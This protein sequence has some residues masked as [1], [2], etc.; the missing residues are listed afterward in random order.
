MC[1]GNLI[2]YFNVYQ[3][4]FNLQYCKTRAKTFYL[5]STMNF[6]T[7]QQIDSRMRKE[8]NRG[9]THLRL[10]RSLHLHHLPEHQPIPLP[11]TRPRVLLRFIRRN[12]S[13]SRRGRRINLEILS[14]RIGIERRKPIRHFNDG[15]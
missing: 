9:R 8:R 10:E 4:Y 7:F 14:Q 13:G 6:P 12:P 1:E 11:R 15:S 2:N 3:L 5:I